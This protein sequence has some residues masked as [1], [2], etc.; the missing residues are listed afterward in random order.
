MLKELKKGELFTKKSIEY[1]NDN[2]VF[3]KSDYDR[4][5]KK[6]ACIRYSDY[7]DILYIKGNKEIF[8]DFIF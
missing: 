1:P 6:Y 4:T 2:Q 7:N 5:S 8:T 3:I